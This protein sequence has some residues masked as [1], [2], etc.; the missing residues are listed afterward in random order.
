MTLVDDGTANFHTNY[1]LV[2]CF[3]M[4]Q[5]Y[6]IQ[7]QIC[8]IVHPNKVLQLFPLKSNISYLNMWL[9]P[10][11]IKNKYASRLYS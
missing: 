4:L 7:D 2:N 6:F 11:N 1:W 5:Y 9:L 3:Q 8:I 10:I